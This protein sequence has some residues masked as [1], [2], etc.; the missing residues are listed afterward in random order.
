VFQLKDA[1]G[2]ACIPLSCVAAKKNNWKK[3]KLIFNL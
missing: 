2:G 1:G 3:K